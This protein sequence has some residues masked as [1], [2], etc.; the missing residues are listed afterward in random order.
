MADH[1]EQIKN[2]TKTQTR[3]QSKV[4]LKGKTY[5]IQPKRGE[6]G[7]P[8]GRILIVQKRI[9]QQPFMISFSDAK[10]EGGYTPEQFEALYSKMY[11]GWTERYAYTFR[12]IL[13][14]SIYPTTL[15]EIPSSS[16]SKP[17]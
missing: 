13:R 16:R 14:E 7:I 1:V 5:S 12:F 17:E 3:R 10:A 15:V 11:P 4:Y 8:E 6:P 2:G 9:E